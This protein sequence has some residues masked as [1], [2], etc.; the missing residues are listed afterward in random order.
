MNQNDFIYERKP[1]ENI[2]IYKMY[3]FLDIE[4]RFFFVVL[5]LSNT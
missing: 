5:W 3:V 4:G 2:K 1:Q